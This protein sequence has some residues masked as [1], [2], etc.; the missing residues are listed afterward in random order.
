P[1]DDD[2]G[3]AAMIKPLPSV[4]HITRPT[5]AHFSDPILRGSPPSTGTSR[6]VEKP[7]PLALK[8]PHAIRV[9]SGDHAGPE[10]EKRSGCFRTA[11]ARGWPLPSVFAIINS[12]SS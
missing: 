2:S 4:S 10:V 5:L 11:I 6:T 8:I 1:I 9:P 7:E 12:M 3:C